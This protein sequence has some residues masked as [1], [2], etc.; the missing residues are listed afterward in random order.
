MDGH[1]AISDNMLIRVYISNV[2]TLWKKRLNLIIHWD[3]TLLH[4][5]YGS[6]Q[7][8]LILEINLKMALLWV[9][10]EAGIETH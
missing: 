6:L 1:I 7:R 9:I 4:L 8:I 2:L 10:T 5:D 3:L